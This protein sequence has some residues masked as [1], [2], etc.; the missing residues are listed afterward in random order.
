MDGEIKH[1]KDLLTW[2]SA[3][4]LVLSVYGV[5]KDFPQIERFGLVSQMNRSALSITSNVAEGFG[6]ESYKEKA[7]FYVTA[8]GSLHE[9]EN[10]IILAY[11]LQYL[12]NDTYE[13]MIQLVTNTHKLLNAFIKKTREIKGEWTSIQIPNS[14]F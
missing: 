1:F 11:D 2:Q 7:Y 5:T 10:Q 14:K 12:S 4:L 13:R 6:R 9:L 3:H 8:K